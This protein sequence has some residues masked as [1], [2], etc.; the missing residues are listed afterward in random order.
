MPTIRQK[1]RKF[2]RLKQLFLWSFFQSFYVFKAYGWI[3]TNVEGILNGFADRLLRL[4][5]YICLIKIIKM[6]AVGFEPTNAIKR[7]LFSGQ[8]Q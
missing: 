3:C 1:M 5:A 4:L 7:Y 2:L 8:A 6:E